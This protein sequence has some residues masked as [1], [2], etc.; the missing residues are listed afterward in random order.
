MKERLAILLNHN[1]RKVN[2][3]VLKELKE[4]S[5]HADFYITRTLEEAE[6][7]LKKIAKEE[8]DLVFTGGGDGTICHAITRLNELCVGKKEPLIGVLPL[9]TGN[10]ISSFLETHVELRT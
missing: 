3:K 5:P 6:N 1:A 7:A 4:A 2:R 9:G 10:A 8:Y